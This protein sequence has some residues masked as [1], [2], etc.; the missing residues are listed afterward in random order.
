MQP[1]LRISNTGVSTIGTA[2]T[3]STRSRTVI[4]I[5][6]YHTPVCSTNPLRSIATPV[7]T[8]VAVLKL[9]ESTCRLF[10]KMSESQVWKRGPA[11]AET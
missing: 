2:R 4:V 7:P 8:Q 11:D 5:D 1:D 3:N 10:G 9:I 6:T